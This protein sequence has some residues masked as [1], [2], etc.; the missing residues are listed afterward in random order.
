MKLEEISQL[1]PFMM[2]LIH[3]MEG[4][5]KDAEMPIFSSMRELAKI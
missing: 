3:Q 1:Q 5:L 2:T 4:F